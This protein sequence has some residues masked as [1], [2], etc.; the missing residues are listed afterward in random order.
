MVSAEVIRSRVADTL[1]GKL[2]LRDFHLWFASETSEA[3]RWTD[4]TSKKMAS[5]IDLSLSEYTSGHLTRADLLKDLAE[6]A[7]IDVPAEHARS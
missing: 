7:G 4:E 3:H 6:F 2:P 1:S 5:E